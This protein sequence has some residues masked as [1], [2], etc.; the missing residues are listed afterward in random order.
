MPRPAKR[1]VVIV[2]DDD[3]DVPT[4][5]RRQPSSDS[6]RPQPQVSASSSFVE[7]DELNN[8]TQGDRQEKESELYGKLGMKCPPCLFLLW[9]GS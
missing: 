3:S 2:I 4:P 8:V 6:S 1:P 7:E 5:K 9:I